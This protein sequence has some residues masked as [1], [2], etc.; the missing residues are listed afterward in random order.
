MLCAHGWTTTN[1]L[2]P[3]TESRDEASF[4]TVPKQVETGREGLQH[5]RGRHAATPRLP[6]MFSTESLTIAS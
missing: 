6:M 3:G 1:A 4:S 2:P 5:I